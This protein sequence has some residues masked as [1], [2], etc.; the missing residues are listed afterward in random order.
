MRTLWRWTRWPMLLGLA[1]LAFYLALLD[2]RI[3]TAFEGRRWDVPAR[4]FAQPTEIYAGRGLSQDEFLAHL[5]ALGYRRAVTVGHSGEYSVS[6]SEVA[7]RTR[8]FTFWDGEQ[9]ALQVQVRF[10][11]GQVQAVRSG[12]DTLPLLRLDPL[13]IGSLLPASQEDR[14]VVSPVDVPVQL[15]EALVAVEDRKFYRH[16]GVDP[17]AIAR[18]A[19]VNLRSGRIRQGGSTI[20]QQLVK[21]YFL[22][23]RQTLRRKVSEAFMAVLLD[24]RYDKQAL[25]NGYINEVFLGQDGARAVHGFALGSQFYFGVPLKELDTARLAMLVG[26]IRGPSYYDPRRHPERARQRRDDVID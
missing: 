10:R 9:P 7:L 22:N 17:L 4:V 21:N 15:R 18:A 19:W 14:I 26:I 20:T 11:R 24:A 5:D 13:M 16:H 3:T 2:R 8:P 25:L 12:D 1:A 23:N 6:R